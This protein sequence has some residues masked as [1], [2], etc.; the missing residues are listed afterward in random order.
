MSN[1]SRRS[2]LRTTAVGS[3]AGLAELGFLSRLTP[4][5]ANDARLPTDIVRLR[6]EVEPLVRLL[7]ETPRDRVL[8][9]IATAIRRGTSYV[10]VL[11]A[12]LLAGVRNVQSRPAVGFKF[13]A[14]LVVNSAHLASLASP[15][16]DRW[17]PIF[18]AIDEFKASQARDVEEGNW[19]MS[20]VNESAVPP[21]HKAR[22]MFL[23]AMDRWDEEAADLSVASLARTAG[24]SDL[25]EI[26]A[27]LGVRDFRAIGHK[28][29]FVANSWRTLH[30]IGWQHSE[31]VLRSLASALLN[32]NNEP[33]PA[34]SD[35][36]PDRPGRQ[37]LE[38]LKRIRPD[39]LNG[40]TDDGATRSLLATLRS[41]SDADACEKVV[42]LL[43]AGVS[44]RTV[45]DALFVGAGELLMRQPGIVALHAVTST[46]A[47][48]YIFE[49]SGT[50][51]TRLLALLQNAAFLPLFRTAMSGRGKVGDDRIED[52]QPAETTASA[53]ELIGE[54]FADVSANRPAAARKMLAYLRAGHAPKDL[55][56]AARRL[57]FLKGDDS[58]DYKFSSA[59]LEDYHHATPHW[60]DLYL[61]SSVFQLNGS[62]ARDNGLVARIRD[63][64]RA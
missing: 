63:A 8:E 55:I 59:V 60:R 28:A 26:F 5:S 2:F 3:V 46:N 61:S 39:W 36:A 49:A 51:E 20:A 21:A 13:H 15:D 9:A 40:N 7:E 33:N 31:P 38:R 23:D 24:S 48:R 62:G 17:L 32:H 1:A 50:A 43:N 14:V 22:P 58:H 54:I 25:F 4:I 56:D 6:P 64:F 37:N 42:E 16:S 12:L 27:R 35:L 29:I 30:C 34:T 47:M 52:L 11:A 19:T 18:W 57:V 44:A 53:P 10:E 41:G 45:Y